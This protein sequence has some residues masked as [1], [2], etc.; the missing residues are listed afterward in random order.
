MR[1]NV[2]STFRILFSA[3]FLNISEDCCPFD[4]NSLN[5]DTIMYSGL[6]VEGRYA[7]M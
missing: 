5:T 4:I 2:M 7:R 3:V 6:F 1:L